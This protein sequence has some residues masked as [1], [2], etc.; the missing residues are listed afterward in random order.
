MQDLLEKI[1]KDRNGRVNMRSI[2]GLGKP[3]SK[4]KRKDAE[5][6]W[7]VQTT[8]NNAINRRELAKALYGDVNVVEK[9]GI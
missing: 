2:G 4:R 1:A 8:V 9:R 6:E 7:Q 3:P 5:V